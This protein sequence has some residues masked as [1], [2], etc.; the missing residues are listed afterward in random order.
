MLFLDI[1]TTGLNPFKHDISL[2]QVMNEAGKVFLIQDFEKLQKLKQVL[3]S[4]KRH[5]KMLKTEVNRTNKTNKTNTLTHKDKSSVSFVSGNENINNVSVKQVHKC[6]LYS[7][8]VCYPVSF[9][10]FVSSA[11]FELLQNYANNWQTS[12]G[13]VNS[14]N[15]DTFVMDF[16]IDQAKAGQQH[17][18]EEVRAA[19]EKIFKIVPKQETQIVNTAE[20]TAKMI[21]ELQA[22]V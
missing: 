13:P 19:A 15:I 9:V 17:N 21:N 10:S 14:S 16:T 8:S 2:V 20:D 6:A 1:E 18:K 7:D 3:E 11:S 22:V 12:N 5:Y 4:K